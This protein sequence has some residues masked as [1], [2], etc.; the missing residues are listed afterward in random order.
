MSCEYV[1]QYYGVPAVIGRIVTVNGR[2]GII[3]EDRGHY[4]GV[5][6]DDSKPGVICNAHP[7]SQ[8]V[9]GEMGIIRKMTK[10]QRRYQRF[11]DVGECFNNFRDF[12]LYETHRERDAQ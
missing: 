5:N 8:V 4:I 1:R 12:L 6:F 2:R 9:Y 3:A 10:S 7:V 11:L